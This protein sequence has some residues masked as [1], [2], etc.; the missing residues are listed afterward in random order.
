MDGEAIADAIRDAAGYFAHRK[1]GQKLHVIGLATRG[2]PLAE[3]LTKELRARGVDAVSGSIDPSFHRD[4]YHTRSRLKLPSAETAPLQDIEGEGVLLVDDVLYTG[5]SVRAAMSGLLEYGRPK[6]VRL[7]VLIERP[8]RELPIAAD[9]A[10]MTLEGRLNGDV[11]VKLL[12]SD[13]V[14]GVHLYK[15]EGR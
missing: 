9:Y 5:R 13:G 11:S 4:D 7:W 12:E 6:Y 3:R 15:E 1:A 10:G 2:V 14:D 8:G